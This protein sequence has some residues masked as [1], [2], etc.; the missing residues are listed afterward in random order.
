M[1][2]RIVYTQQGSIEVLQVTGSLFILLIVCCCIV[3]CLRSYCESLCVRELLPQPLFLLVCLIDNTPR[4]VT[5]YHIS[6][7]MASGDSRPK[8]DRCGISFRNQLQVGQVG[9]AGGCCLRYID[10]PG[11]HQINKDAEL[12]RVLPGRAQNSVWVLMPDDR[13]APWGFH[14][15]QAWSPVGSPLPVF[16]DCAAH[17]SLRGSFMIDLLYF[18]NRACADAIWVAKPSRNSGTGSRS[19]PDLPVLLPRNVKQRTVQITFIFIYFR[20][21]DFAFAF[22]TRNAGACFL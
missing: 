1:Y 15:Q 4:T 16:G 17:A 5:V 7:T 14:V 12:T 22:K 2:I 3:L 21:F 13:A 9:H 20:V 10:R 8:A 19:S 11:C 18:T 6:G